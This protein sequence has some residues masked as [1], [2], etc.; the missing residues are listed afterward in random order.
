MFKTRIFS[1]RVLANDGEIDIV[2]T[3]RKTGEGLAEN[4]GRIDVELLTHGNV[5]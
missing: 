2:M 3:R 1:F 4:N 5:P